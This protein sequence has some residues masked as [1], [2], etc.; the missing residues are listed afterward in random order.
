MYF[1]KVT[2]L[3]SCRT[4]VCR[5]WQSDEWRNLPV[6]FKCLSKWLVALSSIRLS[7]NGWTS[8]RERERN[9]VREGQGERE[10]KEREIAVI[11]TLEPL[12]VF[13]FH[14]SEGD[15]A[16]WKQALPGMRLLYVH[17]PFDI[18]ILTSEKRRAKWGQNWAPHTG[19]ECTLPYCETGT[20]QL[21]WQV[22]DSSMFYIN[23]TGVARQNN[24]YWTF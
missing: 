7:Q 4:D 5:V 19:I 14:A 22:I 15:A 12:L 23:L 13:V 10:R 6:S 21:T 18:L 16:A 8:E 2:M 9:W 20:T 1:R 24:I 11:R 3:R 17:F